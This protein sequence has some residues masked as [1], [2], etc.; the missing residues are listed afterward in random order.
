MEMRVAR[1]SAMVSQRVPPDREDW[2]LDWQRGIAEAAAAFSGYRGTEV[3]P[4]AAGQGETWIVVVHFDAPEQLQAWLDSPVR[5]QW[6]ERLRA[7]IGTF[8]VKALAGGLAPWFA[9]FDTT[10]QSVPTPSWKMA[11]MVLLGLYPT[12][13]GL[14]L[15]PG[16]FLSPLGL[17]VSMLLGN[18][19]S[20]ALL[21]WAVMPAL[22][23]VFAGWLTANGPQRR[24][25]SAAG[26]VVIVALLTGLVLLFRRVTG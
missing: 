12:V 13:M 20:I 10:G 18:A 25:V 1:A 19:L 5:A 3:Y 15:F 11:L 8:T 23:T 21:Q 24:L 6:V 16:P 7:T 14:A 26:V 4:P 22:N 17:A 9:C 2:F